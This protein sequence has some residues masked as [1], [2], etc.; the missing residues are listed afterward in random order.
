MQVT[1]LII[2]DFYELDEKNDGFQFIECE[3]LHTNELDEKK[4]LVDIHK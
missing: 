2:E 4:D 1:Q 3:L